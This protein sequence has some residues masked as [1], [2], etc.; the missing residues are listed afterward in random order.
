MT[1]GDI[2]ATISDFVHSAELAKAAGYDGVEI[3]GSEGYLLTQ[4][5]ATRTNQRDDD[6]GGSFANRARLTLEVVRRTRAAVGKGFVIMFRLSVLDLVDGGLNEAEIVDLA[7]AVEAAG[8]DILN[9]GIGWHE[10]PIPT[11]AQA[12]PRAAFVDHT[13]KL[14]GKVGIPLVASNRINTPEVAEEV[15]AAG[16][17]DM[18][19]MARPFLADPAFVA[20]A[21]TGR[22]EEINT[23]I[24]CNQ[25]CLD[26][27]F[28]GRV[29]SCLVNPRACHE[30]T[31]TI[32]TATQKKR[33]AVAG[34]GVAGLAAAVTAAER[35]HAVTLFEAAQ[36]VGGQFNL[37]RNVPGKYEFDETLRYFRTML[38]KT[39]VT[40]KLGTRATPEVLSADD[41][42]EVVL[43]AGVVPRRPNID[44]IDGSRVA[45]YGDILNG[46]VR[47]GSRVAIIGGGGIAFDVALYLLE[48][49]DPAFTDP[50]AFRRSWGIGEPLRDIEP[51]HQ[52]T[53]LQRTQGP[54]GRGLGKTTGWI[55][56]AV[57]KRNRVR[58]LSGVVYRR[59]DADGV[60][61]ERDRVAE[62]IAADTVVICAGQEPLNDLM[63]PL[64]A[65]GV[66]VH[67]VGGAREAKEL[68]AE[69]AIREGME[70]AA[71]I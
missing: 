47:A 57:L 8:A 50:V 24:A 55:H 66:S 10:A 54:M 9:S 39:G 20:K 68:D 61:I 28:V 13:A 30:T 17:A 1:A 29:S 33:V 53:M 25:A 31:L 2:E 63:R 12:V 26:R 21:E 3:M 64:E 44:G 58:Q 11:I 34:A 52:I 60:H 56:R 36:D 70:V 32:A 19:S 37:A 45:G 23:C 14:K 59:I 35:G 67:V 18:V 48:A 46:A 62:T 7:Q 42:D 38:A 71:R 40:V 27:Y 65:A 4:F 69:R 51:R 6:W 49:G 41:Y 15:I 43:A 5:M 22:A 16:R